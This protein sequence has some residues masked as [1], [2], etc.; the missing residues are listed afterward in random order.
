MIRFSFIFIERLNKKLKNMWSMNY[1]QCK[2][3]LVSQLL[4]LHLL[5]ALPLEHVQRKAPHFLLNDT[6]MD[7][8]SR[9]TGTGTGGAGEPCQPELLKSQYNS[10]NWSISSGHGMDSAVCFPTDSQLIYNNILPKLTHAYIQQ[11]MYQVCLCVKKFIFPDI[12]AL[13]IN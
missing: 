13:V 5:T 7:Y 8:K 1:V 3:G 6:E 4:W 9:L 10:L 2:S 11:Y 12:H